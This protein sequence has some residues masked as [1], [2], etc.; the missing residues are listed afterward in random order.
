MATPAAKRA[1]AQGR[2]DAWMTEL[3]PRISVRVI[4]RV[5]KRHHVAD[6]DAPGNLQ[7]VVR[8][9]VE[10]DLEEAEAVCIPLSSWSMG[11]LHP[12][13]VLH[14]NGTDLSPPPLLAA[15]MQVDLGM[16]LATEVQLRCDDRFI[17][18]W[19]YGMPNPERTAHGSRTIEMFGE[20]PQASTGSSFD[21]DFAWHARSV[22]GAVLFQLS[23]GSVGSAAGLF[24]V[25]HIRGVRIVVSTHE[26]Y[27]VLAPRTAN[28]PALLPTTR[29]EAASVPHAAES[30]HAPE[31]SLHLAL[32]D[33]LS[34]RAI[35]SGRSPCTLSSA[36]VHIHR[37]LS[38][39]MATVDLGAEPVELPVHIDRRTAA[40]LPR[41]DIA[42]TLCLW[43][44]GRCVAFATMQLSPTPVA[45]ATTTSTSATTS[46]LEQ[47]RERDGVLHDGLDE[48]WCL[49][50][51]SFVDEDGVTQ[52]EQCI[53]TLSCEATR[54]VGGGSSGYSSSEEAGSRLE[55]DGVRLTMLL[56]QEVFTHEGERWD[57]RCCDKRWVESIR[58]PV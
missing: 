43:Q 36:P 1:C 31:Y 39:F 33:V 53:G 45:Q 29:P 28:L 4:H 23:P 40:I 44:R 13:G 41:E 18:L 50:E 25:W 7:G 54:L 8:V 46:P 2:R 3:K 51:C 15:R 56:P 52:H 55:L 57:A 30:E 9:W 12:G 34:G 22:D 11:S 26:I 20:E 6:D 10:G 27:R 35:A 17:R 47:G 16:K 14:F 48:E 42:I 5:L 32:I 24:D 58:P 37:R 19:R 49:G 38:Y 21:D